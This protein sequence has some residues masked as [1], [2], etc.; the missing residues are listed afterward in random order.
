MAYKEFALNEHTQ[1][2]IYKR[3]GCH[4]LRLSI[5]PEGRVKVTIPAWAA[6]RAGL[7]F[8]RSKQD[9]IRAHSH[10]PTVLM[11]GQAI[12]KYHHLRLV[13]A[14]GITRP[15]SRLTA[16]EIIVRYPSLALPSHPDVQAVAKRAGL[17]ALR[18]QADQLLP[19]RLDELAVQHGFPYKS[20]SARWLKSRWG[21]CDTEKHIV[22]NIFLLQLPWDLI[23][24]VLLHE[25]THTRVLRHG[26]DFWQILEEVLPDARMRRKAIRAYQPYFMVA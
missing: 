4:N 21:S 1:V 19:K 23:D 17:K 26:P 25:L 10:Q 16:N 7:E 6:Y 9:W 3:R 2:V 8:A 18:Q 13:S 20:V 24:Y 5:T 12:G 11:H 14:D 22:L 15:T